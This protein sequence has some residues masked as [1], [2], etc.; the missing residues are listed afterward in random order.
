MRGDRD[1]A[2]G[3]LWPGMANAEPGP[4]V[5]G[6]GLRYCDECGAVKSR[7]FNAAIC[8]HDVGVHEYNT[9]ERLLAFVTIDQLPRGSAELAAREQEYARAAAYRHALR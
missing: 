7:D 4:L 1:R 5:S 3:R 8:I 9:G 6:H 2:G